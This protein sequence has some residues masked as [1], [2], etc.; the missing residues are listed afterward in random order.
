[1]GMIPK[2]EKY[3]RNFYYLFTH[4]ENNEKEAIEAKLNLLYRDV[5]S[6]NIEKKGVILAFIEDLKKKVKIVQ[7]LDGKPQEILKDLLDPNSSY[8]EYPE[9][10]FQ[11]SVSLKS[12]YDSR[13]QAVLLQNAI[14]YYMSRK[15][16]EMVNFKL[17]QLKYLKDL[18]PNLKDLYEKSVNDS[19]ETF[20]AHFQNEIN[21]FNEHMR[22]DRNLS[23]QDLEKFTSVINSFENSKILR[24]NLPHVINQDYFL[25]NLNEEIKKLSANLEIYDKKMTIFLSKMS[26][27]TKFFPVFEASFQE[28]LTTLKSKMEASID[29]IEQLLE[30][31]ELEKSV[32]IL[33]N[34]SKM[35]QSLLNSNEN[36][37]FYDKAK[38]VV[39]NYY[40][41]FVFDYFAIK[42][43]DVSAFNLDEN[44]ENVLRLFHN[45]KKIEEAESFAK[46]HQHINSNR[47]SS[48]KE[49]VFKK[50]G[51]FFN[52]IN[53]EIKE[54]ISSNKNYEQLKNFLQ[55]FQGVFQLIQKIKQDSASLSAYL[56]NVFQDLYGTLKQFVNKFENDV[57]IVLND[58]QSKKEKIDYKKLKKALDCLSENKWIGEVIPRD[59]ETIIGNIDEEIANYFDEKK[60][61]FYKLELILEKPENL[62]VDFDLI[63]EINKMKEFKNLFEFIEKDI[64]GII[65]NFRNSVD[66]IFEPINREKHF[67]DD[68]HKMELIFQY[69]DSFSVLK[70][71]I[72]E[73][74]TEKARASQ[75]LREFLDKINTELDLIQIN[76]TEFCNEILKSSI[77]PNFNKFLDNLINFLHRIKKISLI[78]NLSQNLNIKSRTEAC[79]Q[80]IIVLYNEL[81][82]V[83][84]SANFVKDCQIVLSILTICKKLAP[85]DE[86]LDKKYNFDDLYNEQRNLMIVG[87]KGNL[88]KCINCLKTH[89]YLTIKLILEKEKKFDEEESFLIKENF[90]EI[91][92]NLAKHLES[93]IEG[94]YFDLKNNKNKFIIPKEIYRIFDNFTILKK[95]NS[96][97]KDLKDHLQNLQN[98]IDDSCKTFEDLFYKIFVF[99]I[100]EIKKEFANSQYQRAEEHLKDLLSVSEAF[101][102]LLEENATKLDENI[103]NLEQNRNAAIEGLFLSIK[104]I[105]FE[106]FY[107]DIPKERY[108]SL[109]KI[110]LDVYLY[111][112]IS[113][114]YH[115][116]LKDKINEKLHEIENS[117][118]H[119]EKELQ[120]NALKN[121]L[122]LLPETIDKHFQIVIQKELIKLG[123]KNINF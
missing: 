65:A 29:S 14:R 110:S 100:E 85:L 79:I 66:K 21:D 17:G 107:L 8:I 84:I 119:E 61:E 68:I 120:L 105:E 27:I 98:P 50:I 72:S 47:F 32:E 112:K 37:S 67:L 60:E 73:I 36:E 80:T 40:K 91:R 109:K 24:T 76:S 12:R 96:C 43:Y 93:L 44:L 19:S 70:N 115:R 42:N 81:K 59:H 33:D 97:L 2:I 9:E 54:G 123:K 77:K 16:Y 6:R 87:A 92:E 106:D 116:A 103:R 101:S 55:N 83:L 3:L 114:D 118:Q 22:E 62:Q 108:E 5:E 45:L 30:S 46:L 4:F 15:E 71:G 35:S 13:E 34:V 113:V 69:L 39:L 89:D 74:K 57:K 99:Q 90:R 20:N 11:N 111:H 78:E 94:I 38:K 10:V 95:A 63:F 121:I 104:Q 82:T 31:E 7:P 48:I 88:E 53:D 52:K 122:Y 58:I 25:E 26:L 86:F 1:M 23:E 75:I 18:L 102:N 51:V 28:I 41:S 56:K 64:S 117:F 49:D